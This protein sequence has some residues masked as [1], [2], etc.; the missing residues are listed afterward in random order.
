MRPSWDDYFLDIARIVATRHTCPVAAV[1]AVFVDENKSILVTG[2]NG[3][4]RGMKHCDKCDGRVMGEQ[5]GVCLAV[6]AE[7]NGIY[8][9][10]F[11]GVSLR[12]STLYSTNFPCPRCAQAIVS[13]G[14]KRVVYN[15]EY[16]D[17]SAVEYLREAGIET[18][19]KI[20][21]I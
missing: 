9:A 5:S 21:Q 12:N 7:S 3:S 4:P 14:T 18:C 20:I 10:T 2:Y 16:P 17:R 6:H 1:G 11:N 8:N 13:V 19:E 15:I